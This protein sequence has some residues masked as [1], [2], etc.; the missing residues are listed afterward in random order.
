MSLNFKGRIRK[1]G[2]AHLLTIPRQYI[3]DGWL[4]HDDIVLIHL[5]KEGETYEDNKTT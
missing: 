1:S 5:K 2:Q 4:K 3:K